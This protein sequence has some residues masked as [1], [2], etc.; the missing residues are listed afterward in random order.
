[1]SKIIRNT[2]T[3]AAARMYRWNGYILRTPI[4]LHL[5]PDQKKIYQIG[6]EST[7]GADGYL[8]G[9]FRGG[10][11]YYTTVEQVGY[12]LVNHMINGTP[13]WL[14]ASGSHD[15]EYVWYQGAY[16]TSAPYISQ[17]KYL[18]EAYAALAGFHFTLPASAV[19]HVK[20]VNV[21]F[22]NMGAVWAYGPAID[23]N[24]RN[25]NIK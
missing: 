14:D 4:T 15:P 20:Q 24:P 16:S 9:G 21:N 23:K 17:G 1:M 3:G 18:S 22:Q 25:K 19:G 2:A 6:D 12:Q 13:L 7:R 11:T 5:L 10:N 8:H